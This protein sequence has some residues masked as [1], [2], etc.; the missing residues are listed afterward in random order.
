MSPARQ[1]ARLAVVVAAVLGARTA[2]GIDLQDGD[3]VVAD[4]DGR[5][6][7]LLD[8]GTGAITGIS[9]GNAFLYPSGVAVDGAGDVFVADPDAAAV[10]MVDPGDGSQTTLCEGAPLLYPTGVAVAPGG[11]LLVADPVAAAIFELSPDS[12]DAE[13]AISG[14]PLLFPTGVRVE[15]GGDVL[16]AD[17]DADAVFRFPSGNPAEIAASG[18]LLLAPR[19]VAADAGDLLVVDPASRRVIRVAGGAQAL[20][21]EADALLF[22]TDLEVVALPEPG[23]LAGLVAGLGALALLRRRTRRA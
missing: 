11:S 23:M 5:G 22:P 18:D 15:P 10:L 2:S 12:C 4:P 1:L 9:M 13:V 16:V 19:G 20:E 8:L 17:P 21:T 14:A 7:V 6:V 3:V